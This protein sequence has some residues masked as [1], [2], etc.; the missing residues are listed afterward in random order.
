MLGMVDGVVGV[1]HGEM[2]PAMGEEANGTIGGVSFPRGHPFAQH[3]GE[4]EPVGLGPRHVMPRTGGNREVV[5]DAAMVDRSPSVLVEIIVDQRGDEG[6]LKAANKGPDRPGDGGKVKL[7]ARG[8]RHVDP[9]PLVYRQ[10]ELVVEHQ[11]PHLAASVVSDVDGG[12][13]F[14]I[15]R[16]KLL[17]GFGVD[18]TDD[19]AAQTIGGFKTHLTGVDVAPLVLDDKTGSAV[20]CESTVL[21]RR[22]RGA[23]QYRGNEVLELVVLREGVEIVVNRTLEVL[24]DNPGIERLPALWRAD[25]NDEAVEGRDGVVHV[26]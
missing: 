24:G 26:R 25:D 6:Q 23:N 18:P 14:G 20:F 17:H 3:E 5:K 12:E 8:N 1:V 4:K 13:F 11:D 10:R 22:W 9:L 21:N 2:L 19:A 7:E 15:H 16:S